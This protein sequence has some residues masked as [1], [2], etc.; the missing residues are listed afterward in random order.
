MSSCSSAARRQ[1]ARD[2]EG[3]QLVLVKVTMAADQDFT[4][5]RAEILMG[6]FADAGAVAGRFH[7]RLAA[8][9]FQLCA[10]SAQEAADV[11]GRRIRPLVRLAAT[12]LIAGNP[13]GDPEVVMHTRDWP[14]EPPNL[15]V[16]KTGKAGGFTG[17]ADDWEVV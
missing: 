4:P 5:T 13:Y 17:D 16:L 2:L 10:R 3:L 15:S 9:E 1:E 8:A 6:A 7:G 14:A 11:V 12:L